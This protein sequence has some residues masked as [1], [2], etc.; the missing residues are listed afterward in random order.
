M[1]TSILGGVRPVCKLKD[2]VP[3]IMVEDGIYR[4]KPYTIEQNIC[5]S[6]ELLNFL[7]IAQ[8]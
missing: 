2:N 5:T 7:G 4:I 3:L 8:P 6:D 1:A